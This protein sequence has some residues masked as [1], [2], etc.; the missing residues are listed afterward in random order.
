VKKTPPRLRIRLV[1]LST[2]AWV[3]CDSMER[4]LASRFSLFGISMTK[5]E[6]VF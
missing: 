2:A 1:P 5:G 3:E 4:F 6:N